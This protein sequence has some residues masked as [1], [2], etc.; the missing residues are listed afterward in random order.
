[1]VPAWPTADA[2]QSPRRTNLFPE[3]AGCRPQIQSTARTTRRPLRAAGKLAAFYGE[4][5]AL[6]A[7]RSGRDPENLV[8]QRASE[9][10]AGKAKCRRVQRAEADDSGSA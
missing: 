9:F 5:P 8:L 7:T 3:S 4:Y 1:M 6:P 10:P 2:F